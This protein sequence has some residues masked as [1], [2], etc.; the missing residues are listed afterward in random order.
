MQ[1]GGL[2]PATVT[3]MTPDF[4]V[5]EGS[6]RRY[7]RWL[8]DQGPRGVAVNVDTGEGPHLLPRER[9]RV[10][11]IF[12]EEVGGRIA[13][14]AGLAGGSTAHAVANA[15]EAREVGADALLVFPISAFQGQPLTAEVPYAYHAA[16]AEAGLQLV[17]FQLQPALG[18]VDYTPEVIE[19]LASID[20][21]TEIKEASFDARKYT[22]TLRVLEGL[23]R[24]IT[25]LTGN[26]NFVG[27][28]FVLGAGGA[29]IGFGTL[30]TAHQVAMVKA[31]EAGDQAEGMRIWREVLPLEDAVFAPPIRNYRARTKV[32]LQAM[33][34]IDH[35]TVRP[36]L[37]PCSPDESEFVIRLLKELGEV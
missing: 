37:L 5:D 14:V 4:E 33:G 27:E 22:A 20:G 1:L 16:I 15:R 26:D 3:P 36:P 13:V 21:V 18:G 8:L 2:I 10:L 19:R 6:L 23:E 31:F 24:P 35:A 7:I 34:V 25:M 28:S 29:L 12:V 32:A 9:R 17:L 30:V 11:E